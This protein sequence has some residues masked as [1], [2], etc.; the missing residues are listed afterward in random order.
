M[1]TLDS[2]ALVIIDAQ[3]KLMN[4]IPDRDPISANLNRLTEAAE[5]LGLTTI[6]TEQLPDK[7]GS[8]INR[9]KVPT[10]THVISKSAF[11]CWGEPVFRDELASH[12]PSTVLLAGVETHVC[13]HQTALDLIDNGYQVQIVADAVGS[14]SPANR[15]LALRRLES[16]GVKLTNTEMLLFELLGDARNPAF[17]SIL[18]L[19]K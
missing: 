4:V 6:I 17:K 13:V 16:E 19:V 5:F 8:T 9:V 11:S 7:L 10:G 1:L 15:D 3:I 12:G 2:T 14:R 18:G